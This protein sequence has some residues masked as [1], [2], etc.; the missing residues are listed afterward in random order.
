MRLNKKTY[1]RQQSVKQCN[2]EG[3]TLRFRAFDRTHY[4]NCAKQGG[5]SPTHRNHHAHSNRSE[6]SIPI[7]DSSVELAENPC[8]QN[9]CLQRKPNCSKGDQKLLEI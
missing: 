7:D 1:C 2:N 8:E 6:H 4:Q 5:Q 3:P 9:Y